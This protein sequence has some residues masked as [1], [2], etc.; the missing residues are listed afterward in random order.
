MLTPFTWAIWPNV[1]SPSIFSVTTSRC[2]GGRARNACSSRWLCGLETSGRPAA[3][4]ASRVAASEATGSGRSVMDPLLE[5]FRLEDPWRKWL[6]GFGFLG[7]T[8]FF[9]RWIIQWVSSER[10]GESHVPEPRLTPDA[11]WDGSWCRHP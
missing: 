9:L 5:W 10:R 11:R 3:D 7:Q 8:V 1:S 2:S 6:I 4:G